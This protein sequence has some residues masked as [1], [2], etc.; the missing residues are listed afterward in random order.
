MNNKLQIFLSKILIVILPL[1]YFLFII[2]FGKI[3]F[4]RSIKDL[5]IIVLFIMMLLSYKK[6]KFGKQ[7]ILMGIFIVI[8]LIYISASTYKDLAIYNARI[9]VEPFLVYF[10]YKNLRLSKEMY[11][12]FFKI[13]M[14]TCIIIC[15]YGLFQAIFLGGNFL[16]NMGYPLVNG[17]LSHVYKI[18]GLGSFQRATSTF[19]YPNTFG[20]Y[21]GICI[22]VFLYNK[23]ELFKD[24]KFYYIELS[25]MLISLLWTFSRSSWVGL[26]VVFIFEF[27]KRRKAIKLSTL[28]ITLIIIN[29]LTFIYL[30]FKDYGILSKITLYIQRTFSLQDTSVVGH[31][32]SFETSMELVKNNIFG[33]EL[34]TNGPKALR[35]LTKPILTESSYFL[36]IFETGIIGLIS[37]FSIYFYIFIDSI[38][39]TKKKFNQSVKNINKSKSYLTIFT[40][41]TYFFLPNVQDMEIVAYYFLLIGL[42]SNTAI[43]EL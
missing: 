3:G 20:A 28:T 2:L 32:N 11:V 8:L 9:Y 24:R 12:S 41:I 16:V 40:L 34:G 13:F 26:G 10:I 1:H 33:T 27:F 17:E 30:I 36:M 5:L 38:K 19:V 18:S 22:I 6:K 7:G 4:L 37:Y 21:I 15:L 39:Y 35:Y 25:I 23:K 42:L 43:N 14:N 29:I 31:L